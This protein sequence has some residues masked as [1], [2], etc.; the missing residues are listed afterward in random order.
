[1][2]IR[3][4]VGIEQPRFTILDNSVCILQVCLST[5]NRFHL[6]PTQGNASFIFFEQKVIM[7]GCAIYGGVPLSGCQRVSFYILRFF[8]MCGLDRMTGHVQVNCQ[9]K[10][11]SMW[12]GES[13]NS[14]QT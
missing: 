5:A 10:N 1:M 4:N 8:R 7:A 2:V 3:S 11:P 12:A 14:V 6:S 13:A 9:N